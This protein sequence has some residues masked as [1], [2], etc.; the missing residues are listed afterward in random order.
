MI[1][2]KIKKNILEI[3]NK[4]KSEEIST[5]I[6][7]ESM[8]TYSRV[9]LFFSILLGMLF[10]LPGLFA[11]INTIQNTDSIWNLS[12]ILMLVF[13]I[14]GIIDFICPKLR[15][16]MVISEYAARIFQQKRKES[17]KKSLKN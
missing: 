14:G 11:V 4:K 10:L 8:K 16:L 7:N 3:E 13:S 5:Y 1:N 12:N 17:L 9:K 6:E 2:L 15:K